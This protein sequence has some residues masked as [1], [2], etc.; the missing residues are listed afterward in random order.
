MGK[1]RPL[2]DESIS[3]TGRMGGGGGRLGDEGD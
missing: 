2:T 3:T 1:G